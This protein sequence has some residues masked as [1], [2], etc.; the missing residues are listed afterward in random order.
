MGRLGEPDELVGAAIFLASDESGY[1][2]GHVLH[3]DGGANV[4]GWT[5]AQSTAVPSGEGGG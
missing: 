5:S 1:M 2:T 3:L 4:L